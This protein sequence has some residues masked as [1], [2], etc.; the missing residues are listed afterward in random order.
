M[1]VPALL[2]GV[3]TSPVAASYARLTD[4]F[5]GL[6]VDELADGEQAPR[7]G[8]WVGAAELAAGGGALDAFLA[9]DNAQVLRDYGQ[10]ARPDV[11]ASFG[12]H[13]YAWPACL[14]ITVPWFLH[15]RVPRA[16]VE[17]VSFQRTLGRMAVQVQ[18][19]A[20]LPGDPA[21]SLPGARVVPDEEALRG[22]VRDA[23]AQHL[24]PVLEGFGPRMRRGKRALWGMATDEIVEGLWYVAHLL[25]EERRAM[26]ELEALLPGTTKPY[27]GTAGFRELTG[28]DGESLPTRDRASCCLFYT[29]RPED[30]CVTCP[31]T[32]DADRVRKLSEEAA[33][34]AASVATA[35]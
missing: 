9:W 10:Q 8:G 26:R 11:V 22:E 2:P 17:D 30:T 34:S 16:P 3:A 15:R 20:C 32:C 18:E 29:L 27:A 4:V 1:T 21:A 14:L 23:V 35:V 33:A 13:R 7:G 24:G 6:R 5:S 28:P 31:R 19:F 25:G 12:L